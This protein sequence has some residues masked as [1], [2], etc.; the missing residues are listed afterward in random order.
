M[1]R[2][3]SKLKTAAGFLGLLGL[4]ALSFVS[5]C[6]S[7]V[8]YSYFTVKVDIDPLSVDD[9]L[10]RTIDSC[11]IFVTGDDTGQQ[12]LP[13]V[14]TK[15]PYNLGVVDFSTKTTRGTLQFAVE[16]KDLNREV[17]ARGTSPSVAIVPN[18][19][20]QTAILAVRVKALPDAGSNVPMDAGSADAAPPAS[21][22]GAADGI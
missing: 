3:W 6:G 11:A 17:V 7:E 14:F 18:T 10:R 13:C 19:T 9:D 16:L 15:V 22:A 5:A 2:R 21:D 20:T 12:T 1:F 4:A 8:Q